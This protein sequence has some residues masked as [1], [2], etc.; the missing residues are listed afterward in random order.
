MDP[1]RPVPDLFRDLSIDCR[2]CHGLCCAAL[3]FAKAE[4]FP[5]DKAPGVPCRY[6]A[7]DFRC[8]VHEDLLPRGFRGCAAYDCFGAGQKVSQRHY[9]GRNWQEEPDLL[10]EECRT[11]LAVYALHQM[12]WYL[13]EARELA[14]GDAVLEREIVACSEE[15]RAMTLAPPT[16]LW[17]LD[18]E[19]C[20]DRAN[21]LLRRAAPGTARA[22]HGPRD[23]VGKDLRGTDLRGKDLSLS[24]LMA[25]DLSGCDLAGT[26]LLGAD[27]RDAD[28][29]GADL[30]RCLFLT[31][32]QVAAA[33]GDGTT[34]LPPRLRRPG[35]WEGSN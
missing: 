29:R 26:N 16:R 25:A 9:P 1:V 11:F 2:R 4:G 20:R 12:L 30:R 35:S 27:L 19:A 10:E 17:E 24:L 3:Y 22:K 23:R 33:R 15:L 14:E 6:L 5:E 7:S 28:L 18:L 31:Q 32:G 8:R 21:S 34:R 13:A